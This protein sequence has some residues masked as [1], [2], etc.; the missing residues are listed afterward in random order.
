MS[1]RCL[2]DFLLLRPSSLADKN[3]EHYKDFK[4]AVWDIGHL[5]TACPP[6]SSFLEKGGKIAKG[7][8]PSL[9]PVHTGPEDPES[10]DDD[11]EIGGTT[12]D[13]KCP[14]TLLPY[15]DAVKR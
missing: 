2:C 3:S 12:Q 9:K 10:D 8:F 1:P 4:Q 11:I 6:I 5:D 7:I 14:L 15:E 13:Y